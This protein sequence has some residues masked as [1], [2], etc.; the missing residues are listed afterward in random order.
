MDPELSPREAKLWMQCENTK[1]AMR[2]LWKDEKLS[3]R[4]KG[5]LIEFANVINEFMASMI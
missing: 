4:R 1:E 5:E 3:E 2:N